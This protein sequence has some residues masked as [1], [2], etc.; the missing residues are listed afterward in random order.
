M[1][2]RSGDIRS[3]DIRFGIEIDHYSTYPLLL[4]GLD[5]TPR[6]TPRSESY[7]ATRRCTI[8]RSVFVLVHKLSVA[9]EGTP[10]HGFSPGRI[11][12]R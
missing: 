2:I 7:C 9:V 10:Y 8:Y 12:I 4:M 5:T 1:R 11:D 6:N 3:D